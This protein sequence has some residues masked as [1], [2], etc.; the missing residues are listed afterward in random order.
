MESSARI[1]VEIDGP[2]EGRVVVH[3]GGLRGLRPAAGALD[4]GNAGTALRL[5][6]GLLAGQ[7]FESTLVGD[8]SLTKRPMRRVAEPLQRMGRAHRTNDGCPPVRILPSDGLHGIATNC[9]WPAR[10]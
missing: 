6:M 10:N 3:G 2:V 7:R 5:L 4:C 8:E 9:R 1:G